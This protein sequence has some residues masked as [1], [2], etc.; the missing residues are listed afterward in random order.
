[1]QHFVPVKIH[2]KEQPGMWKRFGVRWTPT[3]LVMS[4]EGKEERRIEGF[5]PANEY[6]GQLEL[7]LAYIAVEG[8][9]WS[10]AQREFERVVDRYPDTD[11]AP[12]AL[13]WTGVAKYSASHDAAD[14]KETGRQFQERYTDTSWAKRA[15]VWASE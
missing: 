5:L 2:I 8:K 10:D 4:P 3:I 15:S 12:E 1:M 9:Q 13:Y 14:L 6:L 11:A 7:G